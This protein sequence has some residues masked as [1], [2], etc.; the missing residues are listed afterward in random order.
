M[1]S[2]SG[3]CRATQ[4]AVWAI[5]AR[6]SARGTRA[7]AA[8]TAACGSLPS[9]DPGDVP[10][11]A[12]A[13]LALL[14]WFAGFFCRLLLLLLPARCAGVRG[15]VPRRDDELPPRPIRVAVCRAGLAVRCGLFRRLLLTGLTTRDTP[16]IWFCSR[17]RRWSGSFS[18][19]AGAGSRK[20]TGLRC[21][22]VSSACSSASAYTSASCTALPMSL[23]CSLSLWMRSI[24]WPITPC[25]WPSC[26][27]LMARQRSSLC[28]VRPG[29]SMATA[30]PHVNR[31]YS[32]CASVSLRL[33]VSTQP[34]SLGVS[35]LT[36][37]CTR[38]LD[39]YPLVTSLQ[40][41][42]THQ[43]PAR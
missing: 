19:S 30:D 26:K 31:P 28:A 24:H 38:T 9:T 27:S 15:G 18:S 4:C 33:C 21:L 40:C 37:H 23:R 11:A 3:P 25:T 36:S 2:S 8:I 32:L 39:A 16:A 41:L 12:G 43:R 22:P 7:A 29:P 13:C 14:L 42:T 1:F 35:P 34:A 20:L 6:R 5:S 10:P 17:T